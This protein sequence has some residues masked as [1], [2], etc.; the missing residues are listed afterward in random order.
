MR[1]RAF[2]GTKRQAH[3]LPCR[4]RA[5]PRITR[6][7][8]S[9]EARHSAPLSSGFVRTPTSH[10]A[11]PVRNPPPERLDAPPP[12]TM[13]RG[14]R[15]AGGAH[16]WAAVWGPQRGKL[17][18]AATAYPNSLTDLD[19][20]P[21]PPPAS[22]AVYTGVHVSGWGPDGPEGGVRPMPS[23][24]EGGGPDLSTAMGGGGSRT[25]P[26]PCDRVVRTGSGGPC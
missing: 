10:G 6:R 13:M 20:L 7:P 22:V 23:P 25:S 5:E 3:T 26:S 1:H 8:R 16:V 24:W 14:R 11:G 19:S 12:M 21:Y 9:P 15:R 4:P 18:W 2:G 17:H